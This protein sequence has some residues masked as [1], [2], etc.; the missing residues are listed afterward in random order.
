MVPI[1]GPAGNGA[2]F[3]QRQAL[4]ELRGVTEGDPSKADTAQRDGVRSQLQQ[5]ASAGESAA[6]L[7]ALRAEVEVRIAEERI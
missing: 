7:E 5:A 6:L 1:S 2:G 4:G 3:G